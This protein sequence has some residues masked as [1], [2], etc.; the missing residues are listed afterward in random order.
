M[1]AESG[2]QQWWPA[3]IMGVTRKDPK[4]SYLPEVFLKSSCL[5]AAKVHGVYIQATTTEG[6]DVPPGS[7][8]L[9]SLESW[10]LWVSWCKGVGSECRVMPC[11][12]QVKVLSEAGVKWAEALGHWGATCEFY[13]AL[14]GRLHPPPSTTSKVLADSVA[15]VLRKVKEATTG[16]NVIKVYQ[17]QLMGWWTEV[18]RLVMICWHCD[19]VERFFI[20]SQ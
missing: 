11:A 7:V 8:T 20:G 9:S 4:K 1:A 19:V 6:F 10:S 13:G 2:C 3:Q 17:S 18:N 14:K 12:C 5:Y 15:T 16:D